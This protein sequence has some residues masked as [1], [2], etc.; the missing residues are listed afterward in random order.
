MKHNNPIDEISSD[1]PIE[2][3]AIDSPRM[4][5]KALDGYIGQMILRAHYAQ[6]IADEFELELQE[7]IHLRKI[8][9][10]NRPRPNDSDYGIAVGELCMRIVEELDGF[11]AEDCNAAGVGFTQDGRKRKNLPKIKEYILSEEPSA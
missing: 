7:K 11:E 9:D 3:D 6:R 1:E 8:S 2:K 5:T 4:A 10:L